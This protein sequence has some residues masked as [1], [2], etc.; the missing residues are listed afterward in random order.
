MSRESLGLGADDPVIGCVSR[1]DPVK[2]LEVLLHVVHRLKDRLP[3]VMLILVGGGG[4]EAR[5]R[6]LA[7]ELHLH[8]H[9][10]FTGFLEAP[11]RV[12]PVLDLY[13]ASSQK[14]GLPLSLLSAM[15]AGLAV[16]ATDVPGHREV[17]I[18]GE[19]GLLV[20]AEDPGAL[21]EAVAALLADPARRRSMG[22]A[23]RRRVL[24]E[25]GLQAMV[26]CT[27]AIYRRA[28]RAREQLTPAAPTET[29]G[30][31]P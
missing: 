17:V 28:A 15:G 8:Q 12:S 31:R 11:A 22:E 29:R 10:I 24:K 4:E 16:V 7:W 6:R 26:D 9:V 21:A 2:R 18:P 19:T 5:I 23:G 3:R 13:V 27:A 20:P 25:F 14:E 1:F 30:Q